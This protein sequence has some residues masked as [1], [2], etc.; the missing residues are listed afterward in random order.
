MKRLLSLAALAL[1]S[2][3]S[4]ATTRQPNI[5]L[6]YSDDHAYQAISAYGDGRKLMDEMAVDTKLDCFELDPDFLLSS[7]RNMV[8]NANRLQTGKIFSLRVVGDH[9]YIYRLR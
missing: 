3:A 2:L 5:V 4:A 1:V 9:V 8:N 6:I 7:G